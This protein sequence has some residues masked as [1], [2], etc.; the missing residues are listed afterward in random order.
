MTGAAGSGGNGTWDTTSVNWTPSVHG[1]T[2]ADNLFKQVFDD[3]GTNTNITINSVNGSVSPLGVL[4]TNSV[5]S[6]AISGEPISGSA[7]V[8]INGSNSPAAGTVSLNSANSYSNGTTLLAGTLRIGSSAALGTGTFAIAGGSFDNTTGTANAL[9]NNNNQIWAGD[10]T[11][12]GS[13]VD[14]SHDLNLGF[15]TVTLTATP[16]VTVAGSASTLTVGGPIGDA[17]AGFGFTK[18][19]PGTLDLTAANTYSG[20]TTVSAGNL[21]VTG[22]ATLG[23]GTAPLL[24]SGGTLDL[25]GTTQNV[26]AVT[27]TAGTAQNGTL[28]APSFLINNPL[29]LTVSA[30]LAGTGTLTKQGAGTATLSGT[31]TYTGST[32]ILGGTLRIASD[33][34]LGTPPATVQA[35]GITLDNG[36]TLLVTVGT[37]ANCRRH[38]DD[39]CQSWDYT[40]A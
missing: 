14:N 35:A 20:T 7:A 32:S 4:F 5:V 1:G 29:D 27:I 28:T 12:L 6:Y 17:G 25:G 19:G 33:G 9:A 37:P 8:V 23:G 13:N 36:G 34:N 2:Y 11:F 38:G 16:T 24:V 21:N 15:G 18:A 31:N 39:Q 26:G 10:F 22:V 30:N 3:T 40:W